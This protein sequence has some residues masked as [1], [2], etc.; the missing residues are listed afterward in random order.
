MFTKH[1]IVIHSA[2][3]VTLTIT[4]FVNKQKIPFYN[5]EPLGTV[6]KIMQNGIF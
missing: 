5:L 1:R 2:A 4:H 6:L 3:A